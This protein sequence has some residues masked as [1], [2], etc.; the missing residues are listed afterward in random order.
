[1]NLSNGHITKIL[2]CECGART[3]RKIREYDEEF[4]N[5]YGMYL[6][7][8]FGTC[9]KC[10][11]NL[12]PKKFWKKSRVR[13]EPIEFKF[14]KLYEINHDN[15]CWEWNGDLNSGGYGTIYDEDNKLKIASRVSWEIFHG[16]IPPKN[17]VCHKCDNPKC[18][19]PSHLFIG[20]Q[21]EN[22]HDAITKGR[23]QKSEMNGRAKLTI[24]QVKEIRSGKR[25]FKTRGA[26]ADYYGVS[27][28][29]I[30]AIR[31]NINWKGVC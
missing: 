25:K 22:V 4:M 1:M 10:G 8:E 26:E 15:S 14:N 29:V 24:D 31:K 11:G 21:K 17:V 18:V 19:N 6:N 23:F 16:E 27:R 20:S 13:Y 5:V 28:F 7:G 9:N 30:Y 12:S 2:F 3:G